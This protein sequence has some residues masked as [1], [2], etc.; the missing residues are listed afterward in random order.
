MA[1]M[2]IPPMLCGYAVT[3]QTQREEVV[4]GILY[5]GLLLAVASVSRGSTTSQAPKRDE[6]SAPRDK[7]AT[8]TTSN[9]GLSRK[10]IRQWIQELGAKEYKKRE[11]AT[12]RLRQAGAQALDDLQNALAD[13]DDP[14]VR[15]RLEKILHIVT[16]KVTFERLPAE[17]KAVAWMPFETSIIGQGTSAT[18][19]TYGMGDYGISDIGNIRIA[20]RGLP[21]RG[22]SSSSIRI[23]NIPEGGRSSTGSGNR[24]F[25]VTY[26]GGVATCTFGAVIFTISESKLRIG[27]RQ[28]A[29]G[30]AHQVIFVSPEGKIEGILSVGAKPPKWV[31][32]TPVEKIDIQ[33]LEL[34]TQRWQEWQKLG[35]AHGKYKNPRTGK[36][37]M[38]AAMTCRTCGEKIPEPTM[39]PRP[40]GRGNPFDPESRRKYEEQCKNVRLNYKCPKCGMP[41]VPHQAAK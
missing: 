30:K 34:V 21:F 38:V 25:T 12:E 29:F 14:E 4:K 32:E 7:A 40:K 11:D 5:I 37:S 20:V 15:H 1:E 8:I 41:A 17:G 31:L 16:M 22:N 23:K 19:K 18:R 3:R 26:D 35:Q 33:T 9:S 24:R 13:T 39:P 6:P 10:Q 27:K 2:A 36:Y 28:F